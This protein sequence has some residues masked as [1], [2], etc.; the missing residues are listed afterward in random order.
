MNLKKAAGGPTVA[1]S[2]SIRKWAI[3]DARFIRTQIGLLRPTIIFCGG[4]FGELCAA[5][6]VSTQVDH[7]VWHDIEIVAA[8]SRHAHVDAPRRVRSNTC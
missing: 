3:Q 8:D 2:S 1:S 7:V 4:T 5:L 6:N